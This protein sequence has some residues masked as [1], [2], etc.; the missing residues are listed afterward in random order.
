MGN[1]RGIPS[2][3]TA[4]KDGDRE[5]DDIYREREQLQSGQFHQNRFS[6]DSDGLKQASYI[7][8]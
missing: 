2:Y 6:W 4:V 7:K 3:V 1:H 5:R 8:L